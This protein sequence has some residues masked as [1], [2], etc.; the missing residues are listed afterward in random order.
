[1]PGPRALAPYAVAAALVLGAS[2]LALAY[3]LGGG[4]VGAPAPTS[5]GEETTFQPVA[6]GLSGSARL[7]YWRDAVLWVSD[8]DGALRRPIAETTT[9]RQID[10]TR[11]S[12]DGG[13]VAFLEGRFVLVVVMLDGTRVEIAPTLEQRARGFRIIDYRWSPDSL[14]IAATTQ[15]LRDGRIDIHVARLSAAVWVRATEL[16]DVF[17]GPWIGPDELLVHTAS[18]IVGVLRS[19]ELNAIR[20][21]THLGASSPI[22]G[23][24]GRV[25]FLVGHTSFAAAQ[26]PEVRTDGAIV[27]SSTVD[28]TDLRRETSAPQDGVRLDGRW[29]DGR[30]LVHRSGDERQL[31]L[32][33]DLEAAPSAG[34]PVRSLAISPD[35]QVA[36]G[37]TD[38]G[39]VRI[40]PG[41]DANA[42]GAVSVLLDAVENADVWFPRVVALVR[43][44]PAEGDRPAARYAFWLGA[45][46]WTMEPTG[47]VRLLRAG[48][49]TRAGGARPADVL[50]TADGRVVT[51]EP[52]RRN[53]TTLVPVIVEADGFATTIDEI[54]GVGRDLALSPDDRTLAVIVDRRG[55]TSPASPNARPEVRFVTLD[56]TDRPGPVAGHDV[57]W[58]E[59]GLFLI[60]SD[61]SGR[62]HRID[63]VTAEGTR[64]VTALD[65]LADHAATGLLAESGATLDEVAAS[66]DA[67]LLALVAAGGPQGPA[68]LL[69]VDV[70]RG[71]LLFATRQPLE[72]GP[73]WSPTA[74]LLGYT[75]D[76]VARTLA[77]V[78]EPDGN[79]LARHDGRFAGWSPDGDW[80]YVAQTTG[81]YAYPLG[82]GDPVR[83]GPI[84]VRVATAPL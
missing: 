57:D 48:P 17:A 8:L 11:W 64:R 74:P 72:P 68:H 4:G 65:L 41:R 47:E 82:G 52:F 33:D 20:P 69:V 63:L 58:T 56:D 73:E 38:D 16:G 18:G 83:V 27:W 78:I 42:P 60:G 77:V 9:S 37:F 15:D 62:P 61:G 75:R 2:G 40:D 43:A 55:G 51:A 44:S 14:A 36:Y 84:G 50:W 30:Y 6:P 81:L 23:D 67:G 31:L 13:A 3:A 71:E 45:H 21:L 46:L 80:Y 12:P 53:A 54:P 25:H 35:G 34:D 26:P 32:G 66:A 24:D 28:G 19:D 39:L 76:G 7:A 1:M 22:L 29:P 5:P 79:E 10:L 59:D 49:L 70:E